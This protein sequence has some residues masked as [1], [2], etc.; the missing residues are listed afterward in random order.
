MAD[1]QPP[2][3]EQLVQEI[4][5]GGPIVAEASK[6]LS[7]FLSATFDALGTNVDAVIQKNQTPEAVTA[8]VNALTADMLKLLRQRVRNA[9][10]GSGS[11]KDPGASS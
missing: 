6:A 4:L 5:S 1:K 2:S 3:P 7:K 8:A 11:P 10:D 9:L